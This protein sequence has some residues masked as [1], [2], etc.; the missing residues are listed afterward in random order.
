M[1]VIRTSKRNHTA[2]CGWFWLWALVGSAAAVGAVS[3]GP[4]LL[5]PAVCVLAFAMSRPR[6]RR[7]GF[8]LVTG[9]GAVMLYVAW[10]QRA[11]PGETCSRTATGISCDQHLNPLPWLAIGIVLLIGGIVAH[12]R[13]AR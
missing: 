1:G 2:G 9:L 4:V 13:V 3:L 6:I 12:V 8:G 7:S 11:G 10:V 5:V